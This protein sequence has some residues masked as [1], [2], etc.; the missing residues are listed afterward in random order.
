MGS[1]RLRL[2]VVADISADSLH[3]FVKVTTDAL[4]T[5]TDLH[6]HEP[7]LDRFEHLELREVE[8]REPCGPWPTGTRGVIVDAFRTDAIVEITDDHGQTL[9]LLTLGYE[10]FALLEPAQQEHLAGSF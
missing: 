10:A 6:L 9:D 2:Q 7:P 8:L 4:R 5:L 3:P 1:G